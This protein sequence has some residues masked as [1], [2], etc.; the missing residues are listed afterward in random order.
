MRT[1]VLVT[2]NFYDFYAFSS[3]SNLMFYPA[4]KFGSS[5][6][7]NSSIRVTFLGKRDVLVL[8]YCFT[9]PKTESIRY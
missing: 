2:V 1:E 7:A 9:D 8:R 6:D 4:W 5:R 3:K